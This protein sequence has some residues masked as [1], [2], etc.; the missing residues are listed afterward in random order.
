MQP[1]SIKKVL[2]AVDFSQQSELV[3]QQ[4]VAIAKSFSAAV[5]FLHISPVM[6]DSGG[7]HEVD[8]QKVRS[9]E[10]EIFESSSGAMDRFVQTHAAGIEA[11]GKVLLGYPAELIL[12]RAKEIGADFIVIGTHGRK[13]VEHLFFGSVAEKVVRAATVPVLVSRG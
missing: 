10:Q 13:G 7:H 5:E 6:S 3:A 4:A 8:P 2:C 1:L 11:T 12:Q 9:L